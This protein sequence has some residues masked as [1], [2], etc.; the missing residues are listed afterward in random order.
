MENVY[1]LL[2][3]SDINIER[4]VIKNSCLKC[5]LKRDN[6]KSFVKTKRK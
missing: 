4:K 6:M 3:I 5:K 1:N 2:K